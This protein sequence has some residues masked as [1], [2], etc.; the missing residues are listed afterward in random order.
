MGDRNII[1]FLW[2]L[3]ILGWAWYNI[4]M[5]SRRIVRISYF[6]MLTIIGGLIRIP[7]PFTPIMFTLQTLFVVLSGFFLGCY[8]GAISQF[9][10]MVLG[11]IGLPIFTQG[12]GIYYIFQP[13]F[14]YIFSFCVASFVCGA[15]L[16]RCKTISVLKLFM[17]GMAGLAVIYLIGIPY[18]V[19]I[20][21]FY[22]KVEFAVAIATIPSVLLMFV[23]DTVLIYLACLVYPRIMSMLKIAEKKLATVAPT[24]QDTD[25]P[26][27]SPPKEKKDKKK[28]EE[29]AGATS[30]TR[31][32]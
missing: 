11:L 17:C 8:D 19:M 28:K 6:V 16:R 32:P 4:F 25:S 1:Y 30:S 14:G 21:Y 31:L 5:T 20:L 26:E 2:G 3:A 24:P 23:V 7:I 18:Q 29:K 10:Y 22:T 9:A 12:G 27:Q 13:S 15:C